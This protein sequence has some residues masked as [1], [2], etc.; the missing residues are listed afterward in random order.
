VLLRDARFYTRSPRFYTVLPRSFMMSTL[1]RRLQ[2]TRWGEGGVAPHAL[3][4]FILVNFAL[5]WLHIK[6]AASAH[7]PHMQIPKMNRRNHSILRPRRTMKGLS[8]SKFRRFVV[9]LQTRGRGCSVFFLPVVLKPF[10]FN[11]SLAS[12][13]KELNCY[14]GYSNSQDSCM[15][16]QWSG[17]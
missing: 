13:Q 7:A 3:F 10:S 15:S 17:K 1:C 8:P 4:V 11:S 9:F 6:S 12:T 2:C 5:Y 16:E 14:V